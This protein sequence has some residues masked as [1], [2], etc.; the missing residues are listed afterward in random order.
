MRADLPHELHVLDEMSHAF[1]QMIVLRRCRNGFG[2]MF[3]F[4]RR[5]M[6]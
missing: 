3:D 6:K 4:L 2:L 5:P 1:M